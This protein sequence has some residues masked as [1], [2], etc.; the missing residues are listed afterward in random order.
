MKLSISVTNVLLRDSYLHP[1]IL[2]STAHNPNFLFTF[3]LH[4]GPEWSGDPIS[5]FGF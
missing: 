3:C 2:F 5:P 4:R 1:D